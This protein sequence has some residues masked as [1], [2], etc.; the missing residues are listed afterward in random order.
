MQGCTLHLALKVF[1]PPSIILRGK[2]R[3]ICGIQVFR[4][5]QIML[6][7]N[8][9]KV[10]DVEGGFSVT[11]PRIFVL[12]CRHAISTILSFFHRVMFDPV[13]WPYNEFSSCAPNPIIVQWPSIPRHGYHPW[14][15]CIIVRVTSTRK[16]SR[17]LKHARFWDADGNQKRAVFPFNLFSHN[18]IYTAWYLF[19]IR[20]D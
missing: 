11:V 2:G 16:D 10:K 9:W 17:E 6:H 20:D 14:I 15:V 7:L 12:H 5:V 19:S 4:E 1:L 8:I 18:H 3:V 13:S